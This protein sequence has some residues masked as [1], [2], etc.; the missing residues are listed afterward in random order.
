MNASTL[1][2]IAL[3]VVALPLVL[4]SLRLVRRS[5]NRFDAGSVSPRWISE[6]RRDEPWTGR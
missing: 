4:V 6:L 1:L 3:A 5:R 2:L